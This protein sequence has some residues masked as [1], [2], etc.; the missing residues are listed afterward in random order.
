MT[1][2]TMKRVSP[3]YL[4]FT[5]ASGPARGDDY[6]AEHV[7]GFW[8]AGAPWSTDREVCP[9]AEAAKAF[10]KASVAELEQAIADDEAWQRQHY[11]RVISVHSSNDPSGL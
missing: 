2:L 7:N 9:T 3:S 8:L 6:V 4:L 11:G 5:V 1:T 10:I